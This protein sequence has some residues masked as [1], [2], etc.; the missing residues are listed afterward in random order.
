MKSRY[1]IGFYIFIGVLVFSNT[2]TSAIEYA[3]LPDSSTSTSINI[4]TWLLITA[5]MS[6][7]WPTMCLILYAVG[8]F[9][10]ERN[11]ITVGSR[12]LYI[13]SIF[14]W[15][16]IGLAYNNTIVTINIIILLFSVMTTIASFIYP[17][18]E[19]DS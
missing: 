10:Y 18:N 16:I 4:K 9:E 13:I 17:K 5:V 14:A 7:T 6:C 15:T 12:I 3:K 19:N 2:I 11:S 1:I 8:T